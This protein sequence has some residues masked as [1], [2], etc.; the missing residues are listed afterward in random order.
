[1]TLSKKRIKNLRRKSKKGRIKKGGGLISTV[2]SL[3]IKPVKYTLYP[4]INTLK[5][6]KNSGKNTIKN[7]N[8]LIYNLKTL[9]ALGKIN[10]MG[11][12]YINNLHYI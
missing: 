11:R 5:K 12:V 9:V 4:I 3:A 2:A 6:K 1:M 10:G 8:L 7:N